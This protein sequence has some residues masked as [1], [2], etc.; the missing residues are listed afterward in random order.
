MLNRNMGR[1]GL[2]YVT[3]RKWPKERGPPGAALLRI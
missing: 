2:G 1:I 3:A